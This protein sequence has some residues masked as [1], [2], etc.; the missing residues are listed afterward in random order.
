MEKSI[1][2]HL[3][4]L[5]DYCSYYYD[6]YIIQC[7]L[8]IFAIPWQSLTAFSMASAERMEVSDIFKLL[9]REKKKSIRLLFLYIF[10]TLYELITNLI[11]FI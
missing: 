2:D 3:N 4:N 7:I 6:Y 11:I 5:F 9:E 10:C 8:F 1:C